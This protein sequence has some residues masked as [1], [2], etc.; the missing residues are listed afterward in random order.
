VTA[1]RTTAKKAVRKK[2]ALFFCGIGIVRPAD[3]S[4]RTIQILKNCDV[5]FYIHTDGSNLREFFGA[6]CSDVRTFDGSE[7]AGLSDFER[8]AFVGKQI[9]RELKRGRTVAYVTY[10]HP[11]LFSDGHNMA[12]EC[13][14][15]G[16]VGRVIPALSSL[17]CIMAVLA[18]HGN[19]FS[20][21]YQLCL[22]DALL[23][24]TDSVQPTRT[25]V[26]LGLDRI[27]KTG[28]F[29]EFC[30]RMS[31]Q[32]PPAHVVHGIRC[33]DGTEPDVLLTGRVGRLFRWNDQVVHMMSLVLPGV[34]KP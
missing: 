4:I 33:G 17:D 3:T 9:C 18:E 23:D 21:G 14:S 34:K 32:Y 30:D 2:C 25:L 16:Y 5:V 13:R 22:A 19:L 24:S 27:V 6:F 31:E 29:K 11:L 7:F 20:G 28:R 15:R 8:I 10:G 12:D 26:L 1:G